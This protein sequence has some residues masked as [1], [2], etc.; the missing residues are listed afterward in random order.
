MCSVSVEIE[1]VPDV[2]NSLPPPLLIANV[3]GAG[4]QLFLAVLD[5]HHLLLNRVLGDELVDE[6]LLGLHWGGQAWD[7]V[8]AED[9]PETEQG[10][11]E[12]ALLILLLQ[13]RPQG[14]LPACPGG[15]TYFLILSPPSQS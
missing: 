13:L 9:E 14:N 4:D 8:R 2:G 6:G 15:S 3:E 11:L 5:R 7:E 10:A 1:N 12:I